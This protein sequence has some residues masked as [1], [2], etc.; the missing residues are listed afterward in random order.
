M[1][2]WQLHKDMRTATAST[3]DNCYIS[4][5]LKPLSCTISDYMEILI[6]NIRQL[7]VPVP[8]LVHRILQ[9]QL[10]QF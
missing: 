10:E 9:K 2:E 1:Y 4:K 8:V 6:K 3:K 5:R 7:P